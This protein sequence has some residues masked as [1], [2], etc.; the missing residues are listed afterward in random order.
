MA[1]TVDPNFIVS[2]EINA[3]DCV[4]YDARR[5]PFKIYGLYNPEDGR[6]FR[7]LPDDVA[8]ATSKAVCELHMHTSGGRV[9]FKTDSPYVAINAVMPRVERDPHIPLTGEAGLDM[10][11]KRCGFNEYAA[12]FIPPQDMEKGYTSIHR[13][14]NREMRE[15]TINLPLY[16]PLS[17]LH[18]GLSEDAVIEEHSP[19]TFEKPVVYY[20]SSI[21]HGGCASRPGMAYP[22]II[23]QKLDC[24]FINLGFSGNA[25][26]EV[27]MMEY[28]ASLPMS[29]FVYDY[30]H[31]APT[32]EHLIETHMRGYRIV[33]EKNPDLPII[34]ATR[35]LGDNYPRGSKA[36]EQFNAHRNTIMK[37]YITA[38]EEGDRNVYFLD[39]S[40]IFDG[41]SFHACTVDGTHP[42]DLGFFRMAKAFGKQVQRVIK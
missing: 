2:T 3:P 21:T 9:R 10:Y 22:A 24:N 6:D 39:G 29:V 7:R 4:F 34:M 27:A 13:F 36:Y 25:K 16:N 11:I 40:S 33:R 17:E 31:N 23:S 37:S 41:E 1:N 12:T 30:D 38:W 14:P 20:G 19:Y 5:A 35:T 26:A 18:I 28:I 15:I 32:L 42:T 8:E